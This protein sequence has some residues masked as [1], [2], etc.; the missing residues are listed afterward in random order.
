MTD[1]TL[2][3]LELEIPKFHGD[4]IRACRSL[5]IQ[6]QHVHMWMQRDPEVAGK[7]KAAQQIGYAAIESAAMERAIDGVEE[8]V[9]YQGEVVGQ[10]KVYSDSLLSKLLVARVPGYNPESTVNHNHMHNVQ[11]MPRANNIEEWI[12]QRDKMLEHNPIQ[13]QNTVDAEY[14]EV[15]NTS[16]RDVL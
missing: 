7:I 11:L 9:Y 10:K 6:P 1:H 3:L 8:D 5:Q 14:E 2:T 16:L 12:A 13:D 15:P 4:L